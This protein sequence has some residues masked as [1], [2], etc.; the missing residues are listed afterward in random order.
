MAL[1]FQQD[2]GVRLVRV[3]WPRLNAWGQSRN[4]W[5]R[6]W[7]LCRPRCPSRPGYWRGRRGCCEEGWTRPPT[8]CWKG[9]WSQLVTR[10]CDRLSTSPAAAA[11]PAAVVVARWLRSQVVGLRSWPDNWRSSCRCIPPGRGCIPPGRGCIPPGRGCIPPGRGCIP[12]GWGCIQ[13]PGLGCILLTFS[14]LVGLLVDWFLNSTHNLLLR[15]AD[16]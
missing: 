10:W 6:P 15:L 16:Q 9:G 1:I 2:E 7:K 3:C 13:R 14:W 12:P 11:D 4:P 8:R 5:S